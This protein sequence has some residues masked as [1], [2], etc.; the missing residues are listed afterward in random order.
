M[1]GSAKINIAK[2]KLYGPFLS[3]ASRR[4]QLGFTG[5]N[6]WFLALFRHMEMLIRMN[7]NF[8]KFE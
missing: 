5:S 8:F 6:Y 7:I 1:N 3:E 2:E 4:Y